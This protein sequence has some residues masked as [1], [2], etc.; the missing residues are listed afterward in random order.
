M[1]M[2]T[3][4][5]WDDSWTANDNANCVA[6][7][8]S[9]IHQWINHQF[10]NYFLNVFQELATDGQRILE[11]GCG[12]SIWLPYFAKEH[13]FQVTGLDYSKSGCALAQKILQNAGI[14]GEVIC[15]DFF[16]P[17][18]KMIAA[19]DVV[20]TFGLVEHFRD[21]TACLLAIG[22]FLKSGG[23]LITFIPNMVGFCGWLQK[24]LNK[25]IYD[26]H[27]P[28]DRGGLVSAHQRAGLHFAEGDYF[29]SFSTGVVNLGGASNNSNIFKF[30]KSLFYYLYQ[31]SKI[32]WILERFHFFLPAT[33]FFSPYIV[34]TGRK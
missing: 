11:L 26:L 33:R 7:D 30:K 10:H 8:G 5:Y 31:I 3:R 4:K 25:G 16:Q 1:K 34:C 27:V 23:L 6:T 13:G 22:K 28:I 29:L 21:T 17:P 2:T 24:A 15:A 20:V 19:Y 18:E 12:G 9:D 32:M 14:P